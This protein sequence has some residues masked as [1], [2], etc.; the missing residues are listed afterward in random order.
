MVPLP[1][2]PGRA[3]R[4][5]AIVAA[6]CTNTSSG[7]VSLR[8]IENSPIKV[9]SLDR[10]SDADGARTRNLRI[11]SPAYTY[12]TKGHLQLSRKAYPPPT[13]RIGKRGLSKQIAA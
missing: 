4:P 11:D 7:T 1:L 6:A 5:A 2:S 9:V 12:P 10:S 8:V 3:T 13:V